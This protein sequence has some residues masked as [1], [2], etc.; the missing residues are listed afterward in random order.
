LVKKFSK[1][2]KIS[3]KK[4]KWIGRLIV[5]ILRRCDIKNREM[6]QKRSKLKKKIWE[7]KYTSTHSFLKILHSFCTGCPCPH[8]SISFWF[9][10]SSHMKFWSW[11]PCI[12]DFNP[13]PCLFEKNIV[14][15]FFQL[16]KKMD[17]ARKVMMKKWDY[18]KTSRINLFQCW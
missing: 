9:F 17:Q 16:K 15:L 5:Y 4:L 18:T 8:F 11:T 13:F 1:F 10:S 6:E 14:F 7:K 2:A 3:R 12:K